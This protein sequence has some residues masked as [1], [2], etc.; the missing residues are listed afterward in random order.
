MEIAHILDS[1]E[2]LRLE[3]ELNK[4]K[5]EELKVHNS[6]LENSIQQC[7]ISIDQSNSETN[8]LKIT[9]DNL[10]EK[11]AKPVNLNKWTFALR[12]HANGGIVCAENFGNSALIAN[13]YSI[14][15][16]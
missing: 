15:V 10:Q 6:Q 16:V 12:S 11:L 4:M 3:I 2:N 7:K 9:I 14:Q 13:K 1:I 8:Q 5:I